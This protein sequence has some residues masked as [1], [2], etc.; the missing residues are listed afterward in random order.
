M[1]FTQELL[2]LLRKAAGVRDTPE[3][4][5]LVTTLDEDYD[6][7]GDVYYDLIFH[8]KSLDHRYK[9]VGRVEFR[10]IEELFGLLA[11][12]KGK[13]YTMSKNFEYRNSEEGTVLTIGANLHDAALNDLYICVRDESRG[14]VESMSVVGREAIEDVIRAIAI[15]GG[16]FKEGEELRLTQKRK[17]PEDG[18]YVLDS[19]S[20][21]C[22]AQVVDGRLLV[23][24]VGDDN[25]PDGTLIER[26]NSYLRPTNTWKLTP[27]KE[28]ED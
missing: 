20:D 10:S 15:E 14:D 21:K 28:T 1:N 13:G 4:C 16:L 25:L 17:L 6:D 19:F 12:A 27:L 26:T 2:G 5:V 8:E 18:L 11:E 7:N 3:D 9:Y 22:I 23:P 24:Q